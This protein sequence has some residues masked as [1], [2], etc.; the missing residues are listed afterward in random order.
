M[1]RYALTGERFGA[2][3]ARRIG[4]VHDV[5]PAA[6][7]AAAGARIVDQLLQNGPQAVAETKALALQSAW[8]HFGEAAR[9]HLIESHADKR[10]SAEAAEGLA[11]F[12]AKRPARW[13]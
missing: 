9:S 4:L 3:E 11:S 2:A 13:M 10:R 6:E 7:L 12:A 5:V 1:R 8:A